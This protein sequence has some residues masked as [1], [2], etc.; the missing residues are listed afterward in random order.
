MKIKLSKSQWDAIGKKAGWIKS[1]GVFFG[2]SSGPQDS[3]DNFVTDKKMAIDMLKFNGKSA[4]FQISEELKNDPEII[5]I[6]Q[7]LSK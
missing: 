5:K 7:G 3:Q 2:G 1:A 6:Y 4:W